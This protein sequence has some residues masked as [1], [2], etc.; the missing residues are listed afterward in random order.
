MKQ[1]LLI[2]FLLILTINNASAYTQ[3]VDSLK[4]LFSNAK[5][6]EEKTTLLNKLAAVYTQQGK[7]KDALATYSRIIILAKKNYRLIA[8]T[9]NEIGNVEADL[10]NNTRALKAYQTGLN[11]VLDKDFSL[12]AKIN[13]NIGAL[14]LS[15]HKYDDALKYDHI[16]ESFAVKA[17]DTRTIADLANNKGAAFEQ[18]NEFDK[19]QKSYQK[20]LNFYLK[21]KI[22]DRICLTYNNLAILA[23]VQKSYVTAADNYKLAIAY[24]SK[25]GNRWLTAAI[26]NNLGSLLSDMEVFDKSDDELQK[27]LK[28]EKEIKAGELIYQTY[29]NLAINEK[30]RGDFKKAYEYMLLNADTKDKYINVAATNELARLQEEFDTATQQKKIELLNKEREIQ[31]LTL[32]K[33]NATIIMIISV[34]IVVGLISGLVFSRYKTKQNGKIKLA[35]VETKNKVQ[36]EKLRISRELHDN[37]GA[38]LSF[39]NSSISN[40]SDRNIDNEELQ[41]IHQITKNTIRELRSTVW[42]INKQTFKLDEFVI[43][44]REYVK[45]FHTGKPNITVKDELV[46]NLLLEP[47][48]ANNLFRIIQEALNNCIKHAEATQLTICISGFKNTLTLKIQDNGK[49]FDM[50]GKADGHGL[51]NICCRVENLSGTCKFTAKPN[52]GTL[53]E[54]VIPIKEQV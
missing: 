49:G 25:T 15:W 37:V 52:Q 11:S 24:A 9:Y 3:P 7:G 27:A 35:T 4:T 14:Y 5:T 22:N 2:C 30:R 1:R 47:L 18:K 23:K 45:P 10:G 53:I 46:E 54:I 34:F 13:K 29:E 16:A 39:I 38:Q 51:Q 19:A 40:L 6:T 26:G 8:Q 33:K 12:I 32:G 48:M 44:L 28:I 41:E 50:T 36:E 17:K 43:K 42:L 21:E 20:A 31:Q